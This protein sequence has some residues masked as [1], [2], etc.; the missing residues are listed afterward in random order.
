[1]SRYRGLNYA[2]L[3]GVKNDPLSPH[4]QIK[5]NHETMLKLGC[6]CDPTRY[7]QGGDV[8]ADDS[9]G[10][11]SARFRDNIPAWDNLILRAKSDPEIQYVVAYDMARAF[12]NVVA[13]IQHAEE[14]LG[15]GVKLYLTKMGLVDVATADGRRRAI[16]D[17]N[18]AEYE[19]RK[20]SERLS[21]H[22]TTLKEEGVYLSHRDQFGLKRINGVD[23]ERDAKWEATADIVHIQNAIALRATGKYGWQRIAEILHKENG[24]MWINQSNERSLPTGQSFRIL[25]K[26]IDLY[27]PFLDPALLEQAK[28]VEADRANHHANGRPNTHP[29][30]LLARSVYCECGTLFETSYAKSTINQNGDKKLYAR[31]AHSRTVKCSAK[32]RVLPANNLNSRFFKHLEQIEWT[33]KQRRETLANYVKQS[34]PTPKPPPLRTNDAEISK[35]AKLFAEGKLSREQFTMR[36]EALEKPA[37]PPTLEVVAPRLSADKLA[38]L[39]DEIPHLVNALREASVLEPDQ[40]N[41]TIR[42]LFWVELRAG[43]IKRVVL[44]GTDDLVWW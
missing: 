37:P 39:L 24:L 15:I 32:P 30:L 5:R 33:K 9:K 44:R 17:A 2:R 38:E 36:L 11:H 4:I 3:S 35:L 34:L 8:Y 28:A 31:Y 12:R 21:E 29:R 40:A 7:E 27:A 20:T 25:M 13:M 41:D 6:T 10:H 18:S 23:D 26:R 42:K 14:L 1:M 43:A 16:D 22:Y 19:S